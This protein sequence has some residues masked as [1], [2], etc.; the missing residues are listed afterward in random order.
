MTCPAVWVPHP[1]LGRC[2]K[3][4]KRREGRCWSFWWS[5]RSDQLWVGFCASHSNIVAPFWMF[6]TDFFWDTVQRFRFYSA[7]ETIRLN[8]QRVLAHMERLPCSG[9]MGL[10]SRKFSHYTAR[11]KL[12]ISLWKKR[13]PRK[14]AILKSFSKSLWNH[15]LKE[16]SR[17]IF[18]GSSFAPF[19]QLKSLSLSVSLCV[20][21]CLS[22]SLCVSLCLS[23]SLSYICLSLSLSLSVSLPSSLSPPS[24]CPPPFAEVRRGAHREQVLSGQELTR[25]RGCV[26]VCACVYPPPFF[27]LSLFLSFCLSL[28]LSVSLS[29]SLSV[30]LFFSLSLSLSLSLSEITFK[31]TLKSLFWWIFQENLLWKQFCSIFATEIVNI[32]IY[33]IYIIYIYIYTYGN[34][35]GPAWGAILSSPEKDCFWG[36]ESWSR[37]YIDIYKLKTYIYIYI[38]SGPLSVTAFTN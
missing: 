27:L 35:Y 38:V 18:S 7:H 13:I 11:L 25:C 29:L 4:N 30:S 16:F 26:C 31:I 36:E 17:K 9:C 1:L 21:L 23:L 10:T 24:L 8:L 3:E 34:I 33:Y 22:V 20:S 6:F 15:F 14:N 2:S 32:Y 28:S 19:L 12:R 5:W 37:R